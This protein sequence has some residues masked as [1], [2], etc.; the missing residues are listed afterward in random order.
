[1]LNGIY[2][3]GTM[4][5]HMGYNQVHAPPVLALPVPNEKAGPVVD[6]QDPFAAS[7]MVPP[8]SYIQLAVMERKRGILCRSN[9]RCG[10]HME[11][12]WGRLMVVIMVW[13][14]PMHIIDQVL[15]II[16]I[17][18][19]NPTKILYNELFYLFYIRVV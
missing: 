19:H 13:D 1:M 11:A 12:M 3:Q 9:N 10:N 16:N 14:I 17:F 18:M 2:D 5:Q 7:L 8:P 6:P 15:H 4:T